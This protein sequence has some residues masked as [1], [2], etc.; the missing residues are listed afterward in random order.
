MFLVVRQ[1]K[2]MELMRLIECPVIVRSDTF[3]TELQIVMYTIKNGIC[4]TLFT[5]HVNQKYI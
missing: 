2:D 3:L 1:S 5:L 4:I